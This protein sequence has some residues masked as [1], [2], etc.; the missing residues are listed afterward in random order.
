MNDTQKRF[1]YAGLTGLSGPLLT[2]VA[3]YAHMDPQAVTLWGS[4]I[5]G[6]TI[7]I[8]GAWGLAGNSSSN[9]TK[10]TSNI[11]GVQVH[12][13]TKTAPKDVAALAASRDPAYSDIV[14]MAGMAND[15]PAIPVKKQ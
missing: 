4:V 14:P 5:S 13:D 1:I 11:A 10:D 15:G 3:F 8:G 7:M 6:I 9:I 12:V 2:L